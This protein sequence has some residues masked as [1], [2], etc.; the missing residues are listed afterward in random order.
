MF[1]PKV[2]VALYQVFTWVVGF[3]SGVIRLLRLIC[4]L[5]ASLG[6]TYPQS[7]HRTHRELSTYRETTLIHC[8]GQ[9]SS[10]F[11]QLMHLSGS[12]SI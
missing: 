2:K 6:H 4:S 1:N 8:E 5:M 11:M 12:I 10:H 9:M 7:K 3:I